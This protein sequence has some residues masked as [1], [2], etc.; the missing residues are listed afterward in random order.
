VYGEYSNINVEVNLVAPNSILCVRGITCV[1]GIILC[2]RGI[3]CVRGIILCVRGII[4]CVRAIILCVRGITCVR[5]R[6]F[7][8]W[9]S[10]EKNTFVWVDSF[11]NS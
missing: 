4:L 2:V 7:L 6:L 3:T 11:N 5:G 10:L 8:I 1:R 9:S